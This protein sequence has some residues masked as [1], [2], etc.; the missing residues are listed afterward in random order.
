[1]YPIYYANYKNLWSI[2]YEHLVVQKSRTSMFQIEWI[3]FWNK[4]VQLNKLIKV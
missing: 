3:A 2:T 4:Y 1:M